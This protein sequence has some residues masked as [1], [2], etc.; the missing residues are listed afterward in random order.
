MAYTPDF[1]A[2]ID[3]IGSHSRPRCTAELIDS[4]CYPNQTRLLIFSSKSL[5]IPVWSF[6]L[7]SNSQ[8]C[9]PLMVAC[10]GDRNALTCTGRGGIQDLL[11]RQSEWGT[12][13]D[14]Y[15]VTG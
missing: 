4:T 13:S 9:F 10:T 3:M 2:T 5:Y 12:I 8:H 7:S 15:D 1:A 6:D 14:G 11:D